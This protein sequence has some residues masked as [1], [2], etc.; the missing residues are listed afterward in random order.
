MP[1][2]TNRARRRAIVLRKHPSGKSHLII[3]GNCVIGLKS[4]TKHKKN[5]GTLEEC[6]LLETAGAIRQVSLDSLQ[7]PP[8][9]SS[10]APLSRAT[11]A[12]LFSLFP[13]P[14]RGHPTLSYNTLAC[15]LHQTLCS[16]GQKPVLLIVPLT[17]SRVRAAWTSKSPPKE[18]GPQSQRNSIR[19]T[20]KNLEEETKGD[21]PGWG[22]PFP[23]VCNSG[24]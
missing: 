9:F 24:P 4:R 5:S 23:L 21:L 12:G 11:V 16:Q 18:R 1:A 14:V 6:Y 19:I 2:F 17:W 15:L 10:H 3:M 20:R 22:A 7:V 13:Q 8:P